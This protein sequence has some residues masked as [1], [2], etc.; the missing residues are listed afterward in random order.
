MVVCPACG[1]EL[2]DEDEGGVGI[3]LLLELVRHAVIAAGH[4]PVSAAV[5][6]EVPDGPVE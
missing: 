4:T 5:K 6:E 2:K 1:K 3:H